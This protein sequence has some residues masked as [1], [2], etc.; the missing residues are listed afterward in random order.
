[1][2]SCSRVPSHHVALL[3]AGIRFRGV[4]GAGALFSTEKT[5]GRVL[6]EASGGGVCGARPGARTSRGESERSELNGHCST[7]NYLKVGAAPQRFSRAD[8]RAAKEG[9]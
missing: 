3:G 9:E 8:A 5:P 4:P 1:M 7:G 6:G 2:T